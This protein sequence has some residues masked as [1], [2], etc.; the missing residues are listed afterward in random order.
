MFQALR[1]PRPMAVI[2]NAVDPMFFEAPVGPIPPRDPE[3]PLLLFGG[4]NAFRDPRKGWQL[5]APLLP[6]LAREY[7]HCQCASFGE[8]PPEGLRWPQPWHHHGV[9]R[10]P[11]Q[12]AA[13]YRQ[14]DLL[15][16]PS[17]QETFGQVAAEAQA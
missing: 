16:V 15:V 1:H 13:L 7:P 8:L 11:Q 5:L 6:W 14:A 4:S 9:I 17:Q 10:D 12:L 3:R 2:P